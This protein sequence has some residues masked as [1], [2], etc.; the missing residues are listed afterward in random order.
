[1]VGVGVEGSYFCF[2]SEAVRLVGGWCDSDGFDVAGLLCP[3]VLVATSLVESPIAN[4]E[5]DADEKDES[6]RSC[7]ESFELW[8]ESWGRVWRMEW[9]VIVG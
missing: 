6:E 9:R 1:M 4:G 3:F 2:D 5:C 7:E 8:R